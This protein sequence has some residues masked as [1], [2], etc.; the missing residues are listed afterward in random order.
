VSE[1]SQWVVGREHGSRRFSIVK[2]RY[3]ATT[4]VDIRNREDL[5]CAIVICRVCRLV[6]VIVIC[7]YKS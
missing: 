2:S 3:L 5:V 7:S 1:Q 6:S 4:I